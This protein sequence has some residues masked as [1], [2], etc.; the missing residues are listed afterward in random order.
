ME[1]VKIELDLA[2]ARGCIDFAKRLHGDGSLYDLL[3][4]AGQDKEALQEFRTDIEGL[5][6]FMTISINAEI[7]II[8]IPERYYNIY[9]AVGKTAVLA[10]LLGKM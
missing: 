9:D 6:N 4:K 5:I 1:E 7:P 10:L 3:I 8:E 2:S